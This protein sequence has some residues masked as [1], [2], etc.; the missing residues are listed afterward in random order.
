M[1]SLEEKTFR[2]WCLTSFPI[3]AKD[4]ISTSNELLAQLNPARPLA[5]LVDAYLTRVIVGGRRK[6]PT[7]KVNNVV[8]LQMKVDA[9]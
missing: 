8:Q 4:A 6:K 7:Q 5:Q 1:D 2:Y 9:Q 3:S